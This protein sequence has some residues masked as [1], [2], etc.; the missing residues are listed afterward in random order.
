MDK[1]REQVTA[2]LSEVED[3]FILNDSDD[4]DA[5]T[6]FFLFKIMWKVKMI[7]MKIQQLQIHAGEFR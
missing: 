5:D 4:A 6:D 7:M 1:Q 2:W 3:G